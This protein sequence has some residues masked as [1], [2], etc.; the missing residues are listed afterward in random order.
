MT[1]AS[2]IDARRV[3]TRNAARSP[4]DES[5]ARA[6]GD[7]TPLALTLRPRNVLQDIG[8]ERLLILFESSKPLYKLDNVQTPLVEFDLGNVRLSFLKSFG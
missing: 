4:C 5:P 7:A 3:E 1:P 2:G 6:A 8:K